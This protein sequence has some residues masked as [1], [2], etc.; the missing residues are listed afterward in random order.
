MPGTESA[1][2]CF[3]AAHV[4]LSDSYAHTGHTLA[5]PGAPASI[6]AHI[7]WQQTMA[8]RRRLDDLGFGVAE[9]MDTAQ[10]FEIGFDNAR[11]LIRRCGALGLANGFCA[12]AGTDHLTEIRSP[13]DL[14]DGVVFQGRLIQEHGGIPVLLPMPWLSLGG[15]SEQTYL[16]VYGGITAALD[17]PLVVHWLGAMFLPSLEGYFPGDSFLR[18]MALDRAR[19]RA[20]KLS[21]LD[22]AL[23]LRIRRELMP[24]DQI[25]MTGDDFHFGRL[26][27]GG[28]PGAA[29][30][31]AAPTIERWTTIGDHR[32]A[33]GDFSHAL[34]G[35]FDG[36]AAPA[37]VA[38]QALTAGDV[39]GFLRIMEPCEA[40]GRHV[41][42]DP[43]RHYKAGLAWLAWK[44]GLQTN[45]ML[46]NREDLA[47][48][49]AHYARCEALA[50]A[51]GAL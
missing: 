7:D 30:P 40:L 25:V 47:R 50:R 1:R 33:I 24:H 48:D 34:L 12:G 29:P 6:A 19:I 45:P 31:P 20:C 49:A 22:D 2:L 18:V 14:I 38:M 9:A 39:T 4:A 42:A 32:V 44:N 3:A 43:T 13:Q 28:D 10:R 17:G 37:S 5:R 15:H 36:I 46:V 41:F 11:E 51:C 27:L 23:E 8:L 26:I 21:L 16:D 35:I